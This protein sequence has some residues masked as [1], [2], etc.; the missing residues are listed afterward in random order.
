MSTHTVLEKRAAAVTVPIMA[1]GEPA[2]LQM[3]HEA[4]HIN[5]YRKHIGAVIDRDSIH[6]MSP[7]RARI[8]VSRAAMGNQPAR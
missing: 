1:N 2:V 3:Y 4:R 5:A 6:A 7:P 8:A